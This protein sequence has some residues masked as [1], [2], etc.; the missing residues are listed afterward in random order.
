MSNA[1]KLPTSGMKDSYIAAKDRWARKMVDKA[2]PLA[3]SVDRLPP[4]Q[5][6]VY[7][8]PVL[9]LGIQPSCRGFRINE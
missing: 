4:G 8:V 5:R 6:Q 3:R 9:D 2:R 7:N 1:Q